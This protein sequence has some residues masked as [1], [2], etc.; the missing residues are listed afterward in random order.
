[1]AAAAA[2]NAIPATKIAATTI[3]A[4]VERE[5]WQQGQRQE[6]NQS[7]VVGAVLKMKEGLPTILLSVVVVGMICWMVLLLFLLL[8]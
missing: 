6:R 5:R 4:G 7:K 2:S 8:E 1:V 3:P